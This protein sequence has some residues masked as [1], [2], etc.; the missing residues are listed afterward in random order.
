MNDSCCQRRT[1]ISSQLSVRFSNHSLPPLAFQDER[2]F[3]VQVKTN[4]QNNC[5][6]SNYRKCT[7]KIT[8]WRKQVFCESDGISSNFLKRSYWQ[9]EICILS[10][11]KMKWYLPFKS[12]FLIIIS[13]FIQDIASSDPARKVQNFLKEILNSCFVKNVDW[14]PKS[15]YSNPLDYFIWDKK[16]QKVYE[17][18]HCKLFSSMEEPKK[19]HGSFRWM[20][21][22]FT[23]HQNS[24][25][26]ILVTFTCSLWKR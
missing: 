3:M 20:R 5:I 22:R 14:A 24:F 19:N 4:C 15:P 18:H 11:Y 2:D 23:Y 16:Q 21:Y 25:E 10:I 13:N 12:Y 9:M 6:Y 26:R 1:E 17:S 7:K 8:Q